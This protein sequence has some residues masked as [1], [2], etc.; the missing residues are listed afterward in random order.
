MGVGEDLNNEISKIENQQMEFS[1]R[2]IDRLKQKAVE[3]FTGWDNVTD[4]TNAEIIQRGVQAFIDGKMVDVAA[5]AMMIDYRNQ[6]EA[7]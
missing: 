7:S 4:P 3:G 1:D 5:F 2:V 6:V